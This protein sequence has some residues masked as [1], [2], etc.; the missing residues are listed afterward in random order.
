MRAGDPTPIQ[1]IVLVVKENKSFD[2]VFGDFPGAEADPDP[3]YLMWG[4]HYT[5][6]Q[7]ALATQFTLGDNFYTD[8][9]VSVQGHLWLTGAFVTE[10]MERTWIEN[11]RNGDFGADADLDQGQPDV[12]TLFMQLI[13]SG[14]NFTNYGEVTGAMGSV[15]GT[16]VLSHTDLSFPGTFFNLDVKDET[17]ATYVAGKLTG[18]T[19]PP[20]VYLGLPNDH[21]KGTSPGDLTPAAM[22]NDNDYGLGLLINQVSHSSY[23]ASTVFFVVEDDPQSCSDHIDPHRSFLLVV[24]PWARHGYVTHENGSFLSVYRTIERILG[25]PPLGRTDAMATPLWDAFTNVPDY[26]PYDALARTIPD[27]TSKA[28]YPGAQRSQGLDFRGPD[29]APELYPILRAYQL[30]RTGR[31]RYD[32]AVRAA[33]QPVS[34]AAVG[35]DD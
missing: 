30:W 10:Y 23:W 27:E 7:H 16:T 25:V 33:E 11:Y 34:A 1:H 9:E 3:D 4:S 35:D 12:G 17:K 29:R 13:R 24:S 19:F 5:P 14:V 22:I 26:T 18:G 8:S 20:F 28:W 6:N 31:M 2:C 15:G 32:D 21:T